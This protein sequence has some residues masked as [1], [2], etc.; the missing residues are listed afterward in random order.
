LTPV[1]ILNSSPDMWDGAPLP[2]DAIGR[3]GADIGS[4]AG[5]VLFRGEFSKAKTGKTYRLLSKHIRPQF[6][7]LM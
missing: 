1:I 5:S 3:F 4:R 2:A 6:R 7:S